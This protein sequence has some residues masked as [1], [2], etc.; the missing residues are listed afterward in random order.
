MRFYQE[1]T[2]R[3]MEGILGIKMMPRSAW[4]WTRGHTDLLEGFVSHVIDVG[5]VSHRL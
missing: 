1:H 3:N 2:V 4:E 5:L